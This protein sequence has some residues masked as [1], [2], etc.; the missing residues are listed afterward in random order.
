MTPE[1]S[2]IVPTRNRPHLLDEALASIAGQDL[3]MDAVETIVVNDGGEEVGEV[4][5]KYTERGLRCQLI[6]LPHRCGLPAAR[7][8]GIAEAHGSFVAFLDD[9][10][11]YLPGHLTTALA[12]LGT[13][14]TDAVYTTCVVAQTRV[15]PS[16]YA[17]SSPDRYD[18]SY[19]HDLLAVFNYIP[20][21]SLVLKRTNARFDEAMTALEDWDMWLRLTRDHRYQ[22]RH[23]P[24]PTV[25]YHRVT[26]QAGMT[27]DATS[28][29]RAYQRLACQTRRVWERWPASTIRAERFRSY[30]G[31]MN[32]HVLAWL[33]SERPLP[34]CY[35]ERSIRAI[36]EAWSNDTAEDG[37]IERIAQAV[38]GTPY[39]TAQ[40]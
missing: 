8:A 21:H 39:A 17:P 25:V 38:E 10:D 16:R 11:V 26:G 27:A 32:W 31:V 20:V 7:N 9:D 36:A 2:V 34:T 5:S 12:E 18:Y 1:I 30:L 40:C 15:D 4:V 33:A 14:E 19:D 35:Y 3:S 23:I 22:L 37:L 6:T 13:S 29:V 24:S 28:E